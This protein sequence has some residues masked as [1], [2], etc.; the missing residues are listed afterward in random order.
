MSCETNANK[1]GNALA[2]AGITRNAAKSAYARAATARRLGTMAGAAAI[3]AAVAASAAVA[4]GPAYVKAAKQNAQTA[5]KV[6]EKVAAT[7]KKAGQPYVDTAKQNAQT[8]KKVATAA[9]D[10]AQKAGQKIT[11]A[12][13][14]AQTTTARAAPVAAAALKGINTVERSNIMNAVTVT[15]SFASRGGLNR[16]QN[17]AAL[18]GQASGAAV[19]PLADMSRKSLASSVVQNKRVLL[20][21]NKKTSVQVWNSSAG[22]L[23]NRPDRILPAKNIVSEKSA[24]LKVGGVSWHRGT[25]TFRTPAGQKRTLTHIQSLGYP[26]VHYYFNRPLSDKETAGLITRQK[27]YRPHRMNGFLG[28]VSPTESLS[29]GWAETKHRVI[30]LA[31][32]SGEKVTSGDTPRISPGQV[33]DTARTVKQSVKT[34]KQILRGNN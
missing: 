18:V 30:K 25:I 24:M 3:G 17:T 10:A 16:L 2:A 33:R 28:Q 12:T 4:I 23:L 1:I 8:A 21:F 32:L 31:A 19:N 13:E 7:A 6:G 26:A 15:A 34:A 14:Q 20:F 11:A 5:Q 9:T 22:K 27:G 29:P